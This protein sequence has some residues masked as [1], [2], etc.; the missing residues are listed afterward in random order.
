[1]TS[2]IETGSLALFSKT[3]KRRWASLCIA[4]LPEW[5]SSKKA[6]ICEDICG[7]SSKKE[8]HSDLDWEAEQGPNTDSEECNVVGIGENVELWGLM[9]SRKG[10]TNK[11]PATVV[12]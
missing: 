7:P 11:R 4:L 9:K 3:S 12:E 8:K 6:G 5:K 2:S 1:M 10:T